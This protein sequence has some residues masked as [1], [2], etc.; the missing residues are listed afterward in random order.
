MIR[1][2]KKDVLIMVL[3]LFSAVSVLGQGDENDNAQRQAERR[4]ARMIKAGFEFRNTDDLKPR[5][6]SMLEKQLELNESGEN[7]YLILE[8]TTKNKDEQ[9]TEDLMKYKMTTE[10]ASKI[11]SEIQQMIESE[12]VESNRYWELGGHEYFLEV[13][14]AIDE[15]ALSTALNLAPLESIYEAKRQN[16]HNYEFSIGN[17]YDRHR[18]LDLFIFAASDYEILDSIYWLTKDNEPE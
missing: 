17:I 11:T 3:V 15:V 9:I 2:L 16:N 4:V 12:C 18:M 5:F 7:K 10:L 8:V 13:Q 1:K 6:A 14:Q